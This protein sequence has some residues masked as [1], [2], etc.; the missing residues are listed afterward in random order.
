MTMELILWR[1]AEAEIG[2]PD[3]ERALTSKGWKQARKMASWLDKRLPYNCQILVSPAV[4]AVQT[5][6]TLGR[7]FKIMEPLA[8]DADPEEIAIAAHWPDNRKSVLIIGHQPALGQA[9][10]C[11]VLGV[12]QNW[13]IRKGGILWIAQKAGNHCKVPFIRTM[14][15]PDLIDT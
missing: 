6:E 7:K 14:I 5:A 15:G 10:S 9:A 3:D 4:R 11:I 13:T 8:P 1:H 2:R 12:E